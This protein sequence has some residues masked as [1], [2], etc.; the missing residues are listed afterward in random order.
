M[1]KHD[2]FKLGQAICDAIG[3]DASNVC[4]VRLEISAEA[5]VTVDAEL[6]V[7]N[8]QGDDITTAIRRFKFLAVEREEVP[9]G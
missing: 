5:L 1:A 9:V 8:E 4:S 3:L 2:G 7:T 6:I